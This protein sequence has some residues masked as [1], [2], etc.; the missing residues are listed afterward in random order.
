MSASVPAR[1]AALQ[2]PEV[3]ARAARR[4]WLFLITGSLWI[5]FSLIV[6]RFDIDSVTAVGIAVG[7]LCFAAGVNEFLSL[8]ATSG[9]WKAVRAILGVLF[10][11]IGVVALAYPDRTFTEVAAIFSFFLVLKG[12]FDAMYGL[13]SKDENEFWWVNLVVGTIEILLGFWAAGNFGR[14]AVLLVVWIG[15]GALARGVTELTLAV[16]LYRIN[17]EGLPPGSDRLAPA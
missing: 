5:L 12:A 16:A 4:W 6:F 8:A 1:R 11:V 10:V 15:A 3:A 7:A 9:G 13:M 17:K 2:D 14:E